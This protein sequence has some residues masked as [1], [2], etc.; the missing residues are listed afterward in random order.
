MSL[1]TP[2][3]TRALPAFRPLGPS[4]ICALPRSTPA[5]S[6]LVRSSKC[7][8]SLTA[9]VSSA[10]LLTAGRRRT[11]GFVSRQS[12]GEPEHR[13][14]NR[15]QLQGSLPDL[16]PLEEEHLR[17]GLPVQ[18]QERKGRDG[19]GLFIT[20]VHAP[21]ELVLECLSSF[22]K[23]PSMIPVV[24]QASPRSERVPSPEGGVLMDYKVSRFGLHVAALQ[25]VDH[26]SG[27]ISFDLDESVAGGVLKAASGFW[28]VEPLPDGLTCRV[29]LSVRLSACRL[30]PTFM[31][32]YASERALRRA[33]TW[34]RP[35]MEKLW[36]G[37][38][39]LGVHGM[40][41]GERTQV[42]ALH[43]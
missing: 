15:A 42:L 43:V 25:R 1:A 24:R 34:L 33:T 30:L 22:E 40:H 11:K 37:R 8:L 2:V 28:R 13:L 16:T 23:Y 6:A 27:I 5:V 38:Q 39:R 19:E 17:L 10:I 20:N 36:R 14:S 4:S 9:A 41:R 18:R 32:D 35:Y 31:V 3:Q 12:G 26:E 29:W 21:S 7:R